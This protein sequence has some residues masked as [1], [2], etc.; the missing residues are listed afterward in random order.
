MGTGNLPSDGCERPLMSVLTE[1]LRSREVDICP[2]PASGLQ[3]HRRHVSG[4]YLMNL[5]RGAAASTGP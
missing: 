2:G 3:A 4:G 5:K 1:S